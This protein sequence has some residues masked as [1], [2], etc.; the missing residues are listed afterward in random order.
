MTLEISYLKF[1]M[2]IV[3]L[4]N[5]SNFKRGEIK[6]VLDG[7]AQNFLLPQKLA[8]AATPENLAKIKKELEQKVK[9]KSTAM[10]QARVMAEKIRGKK[11]GIKAKAN[12][13]GHFYAAVSEAEAKSGL[14]RQGFD[15]KDAKII[16]PTHIK[17][18]GEYRV[19]VD[20]GQ[21]INSSIIISVRV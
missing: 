11:I 20:F 17:S 21:G 6:D 8:V 13:A 14:K 4:K 12:E 3:Y 19:T 5:G 15:V 7:F 18:A 10:D 16:F 2:K 9:G 1:F